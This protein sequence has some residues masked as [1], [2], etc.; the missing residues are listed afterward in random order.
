MSKLQSLKKILIVKFGGLGDHLLLSATIKNIRKH[1]PRAYIVLLCDR[2]SLGFYANNPYLNRVLPAPYHAE[3]LADRVINLSTIDGLL[4]DVLALGEFDY[5]YN[6]NHDCDVYLAGLL[7]SRI[8]ARR[9]IAFRQAR[10]AVEGYQANSHYTELLDRPYLSH[11]AHYQ[12]IFF[13]RVYGVAVDPFDVDLFVSAE[14]RA[15]VLDRLGAAVFDQ[16]LVAIH[17]VGSMPSRS[18]SYQQVQGLTAGLQA[19][20]YVPVLLGYPKIALEMEGLRNLTGELSMLDCAYLLSK[21]AGAV[22]VDSGIKHLA[23][24]QDIAV[25]E[26]AHIPEDLMYLNG[27]YILDAFKYTALNFWAPWSD[28]RLH[29]VVYPQTGQFVD[30]DIE[31]SRCI[32]SIAAESMLVALDAIAL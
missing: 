29:R 15:H 2:G 7:V 19:R 20:G 21:C 28:A 27:P 23:A 16:K 18:L 22:C 11:V 24:A 26:V 3:Y 5:I 32:T 1:E 31:S 9:K 14:N 6:P 13:D 30:A 25:V 12:K 4:A 10:D 17:A 8:A